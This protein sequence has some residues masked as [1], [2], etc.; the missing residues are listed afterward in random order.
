MFSIFGSVDDL[1]SPTSDIKTSSI[2]NQ[3]T[4]R[5]CTY[6][7]ASETKEFCSKMHALP[8]CMQYDHPHASYHWFPLSSLLVQACNQCV[9]ARGQSDLWFMIVGHRLPS[10]LGRILGPK[11]SGVDFRNKLPCFCNLMQQHN[12]WKV[13]FLVNS[14]WYRPLLSPVC[15][16]L[17]FSSELPQYTNRLSTVVGVYSSSGGSRT[18]M[19]VQ[20]S[21]MAY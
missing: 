15:Y 3:W 20:P 12:L 16:L 2:L 21:I 7:Y 1:F 8:T 11:F 10:L 9:W 5:P 18:K 17:V 4:Q 14:L 19:L 13:Q 6:T